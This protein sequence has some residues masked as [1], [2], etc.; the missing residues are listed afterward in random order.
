M[1]LA[2]QATKD[3]RERTVWYVTEQIEEASAVLA[4][5]DKS[6]EVSRYGGN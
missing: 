6:E 4:E 5:K 2:R 3:E 1:I